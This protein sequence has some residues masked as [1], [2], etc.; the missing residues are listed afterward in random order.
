M[1]KLC[2]FFPQQMQIR[3]RGDR[4]SLLEYL[5]LGRISLKWRKVHFENWNLKKEANGSYIRFI[6]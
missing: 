5:P 3:G 4:S 1:K 2:K 6:Y